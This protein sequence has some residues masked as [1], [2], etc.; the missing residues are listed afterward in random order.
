MTLR[1]ERRCILVSVIMQPFTSH[2]HP[3]KILRLTIPPGTECRGFLVQLGVDMVPFAFTG[4]CGKVEIVPD[5][6]ALAGFLDCARY[7]LNAG[8]EFAGSLEWCS[9]G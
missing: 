8:G 6:K 9:K 2:V 1:I 7:A 5:G 4:F 3:I